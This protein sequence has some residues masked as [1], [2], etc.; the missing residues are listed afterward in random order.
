MRYPVQSKIAFGT[1]K[2]CFEVPRED[3]DPSRNIEC[4]DILPNIYNDQ[5][6][7][8]EAMN[9]PNP[10]SHPDS[11]SKVRYC[12]GTGLQMRDEGGKGSHKTVECSY[13]NTDLANEGKFLRTM[14]QE[15]MQM[16]R[17]FRTIQQV[18]L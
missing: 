13:H 1:K 2:G 15:A 12:L 5:D 3:R 8:R 16:V 10:L 18:Q 6:C 17:K 4:P 9:D 7:Y 14:N 11:S